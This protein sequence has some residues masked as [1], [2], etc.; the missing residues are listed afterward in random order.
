MPQ[1]GVGK[2]KKMKPKTTSKWRNG[3][4][5]LSLFF[6]IIQV[7]CSIGLGSI[8]PPFTAAVFLCIVDVVVL[9]GVWSNPK[10]GKFYRSPNTPWGIRLEDH[11]LWVAVIALIVT[12]ASSL[13][14]Y[15]HWAPLSFDL[16]LTLTL[17]LSLFE[18]AGVVKSQ[19]VD[20]PN[21]PAAAVP[22]VGGATDVNMGG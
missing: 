15:F 17:I 7:I 13:I 6:I 20:I 2:E 12:T 4:M 22:P 11:T 21:D 10:D 8:V 18:T 14:D 1:S 9:L 16:K 3:G 5:I 19:N